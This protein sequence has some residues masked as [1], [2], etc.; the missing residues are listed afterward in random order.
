M[1]SA[2]TFLPALLA[3]F[4]RAAFWPFLPKTGT[5]RDAGADVEALV[6][7]PDAPVHGF[8]ERLARLIARHARLV[9]IVTTVV[10][11]AASAGV[12]QLKADGV[13]QSDLVLGASE[14]RDGQDVLCL[15]YTSPS[16]RDRTR[17][18]MPSS[19]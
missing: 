3:L 13:P 16:P 6:T 17:S 19:A 18:R 1:L 11:L 5:A 4:G 15:L 10:L 9:W 12:L 8:W 14:A 2:L 7:N